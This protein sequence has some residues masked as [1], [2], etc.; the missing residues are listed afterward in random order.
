MKAP[1]INRHQS[2]HM[3]AIIRSARSRPLLVALLPVLVWTAGLLAASLAPRA[4]ATNIPWLGGVVTAPAELVFT[5]PE[6]YWNPA[7][8]G[9]ATPQNHILTLKDLAVLAVPVNQVGNTLKLQITLSF[10]KVANNYQ[11]QGAFRAPMIN[12]EFVDAAGQILGIEGTRS[13][14][15]VDFDCNENTAQELTK[16]IHTTQYRQIKGVLIW[17]SDGSVARCIM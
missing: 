8:L 4:H 10:R 1:K 9:K 3:T 2:F 5:H 15:T 11:S 6:I 14:Q 13:W 7:A 16:P 12:M 17:L